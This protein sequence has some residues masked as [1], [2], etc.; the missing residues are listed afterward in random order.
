MRRGVFS[1]R[2]RRAA[3]R[4]NTPAVTRNSGN[5]KVYKN[6]K[7]SLLTRFNWHKLILL[8]FVLVYVWLL[9]ETAWISDDAYITFRSVENFIHGY[10]LVHNL[11]E[12]VQVFTH[13]F[14]FFV[15]SGFNYVT[16]RIGM[17]NAWAQMY[18]VNLFLS[19]LLSIGT[20]LLLVFGVLLL[21]LM[22]VL[23]LVNLIILFM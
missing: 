22:L 12:R 19:V 7:T 10:G 14:W 5:S 18:Y 17:L 16:Q 21:R 4:K 2:R 23:V 3:A 13:P 6:K 1:C 15:M 20:V 8:P 11:G 9:I